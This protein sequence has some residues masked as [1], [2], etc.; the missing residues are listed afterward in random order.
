[1]GLT[2]LSSALSG[3]RLNQQQLDVISSNIANVGTDGYTRKILPQS[4]QVVEGKSI[5]VLSET[6][7]RNVDLRLSRD[8]WTQVSAVGYYNVQSEYLERVDN[9]NGAPDANVS[10][11][12]EV[13]KLNDTFAALAN[14][15][16]DQ[17]LIA[18]VVDQAI[19]TADK[20]NDLSDMYRT[21]RNDAQSE[22]AVVVDNINDLLE[23]IGELNSQIR[24]ANAG[25]S[26]TAATEDVRD[27]AIK[28]LSELIDIT[29]FRRGDGVLVVQ[30][31]QGV[32]LVSEQAQELYFRPTQLSPESAYPD[33]AAAIFV[34]DPFENPNAIDITQR[35]LGGRLGGLLELRDE[36]FPRQTAQLDE[37][38][39]KMA[40]RFEAQGLRL[41]TDASGAIPPDTPP[42]LS[43]DPPTPVQY[44]GFA[45][46]MQV[47]ALVLDDTSLV[48]QGTTGANISSGS[49]EVIRR[50]IEYVFGD[51]NY[52]TAEN[53][54]VATSVD[55]RAAATGTTTL[56]DWLG[57][58]STNQVKSGLS[59]GNYASISD[60]LAAGG[61]GV[62]G[63]APNEFDNFVI[64]FDDPDIGGGPYDIEID[65]STV[66]ISGVNAAQDL[67]DHMAL[68]A[69]WAAAVADFGVSASV[70]ANGELVIESRGDI[71]IVN[72]AVDPMTEAGFNY[73][74]LGPSSS[75]A[76]DPYFDVSVG[77]KDAVR[78][79]IE[80]TDTEVELLAKLQAVEGLAAQIDADGFLT[81]RPGNSFTNPDFG[82]DIK[83]TGGPFNTSGAALA[84]T[85]MGRTTL[86]D[87]VNVVQ[88]L[89]GTYQ[90]LSPGVVEN[91][92]PITSTSYASETAVGSGVYVAFR[93]ENLGP[94]ANISSGIANSATLGDMSQK[95]VNSIAQ[96][97]SLSNARGEDED[98]LRGLLE[99]QLLDESG[100]N[101]DEELSYLIVVQTAY[102][103]STRVIS[104][105]DELFDELL[106]LV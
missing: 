101:I 31:S 54:D 12:A 57:L 53:Q 9:F 34:D 8:L 64:R 92:S 61:N 97:L 74:G 75:E 106:S 15:P 11:A 14:A 65:L 52:L 2:S 22:A 62:F 104:A 90:V 33:T 102:A 85:A 84:G 32:E 87:G 39:H 1:M 26:T 96:Q 25:G 44:I 69:D 30:T 23:Q 72:G 94:Q 18:D 68:D 29:T 5:G 42:D 63:T 49:N 73:L 19:D 40:L 60:M 16:D 50:V 89:F 20:I 4:S 88:A 55:I 95:I 38:A 6:I 13:G 21:L 51:I 7:V 81:L 28:E 82:G 56:Q 70:N 79:T 27:T 58:P 3:L 36:V 103:A 86:D 17:F 67:V 59:L 77:N 93:D 35:N 24:F 71:E 78:I 83:I 45:S 100:V 76:T 98:T 99:Q 66:A 43:T 37:L 91:L 47:N 80:P 48:Q 105:V 10:V 41:F 46:E